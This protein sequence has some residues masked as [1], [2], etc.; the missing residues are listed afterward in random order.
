MK[1]PE[2][3]IIDRIPNTNKNADSK[4]FLVVQLDWT[5][6]DN[7]K[8]DSRKNWYKKYGVP[9]ATKEQEVALK[10]LLKEVDW[11]GNYLYPSKYQFIFDKYSK[12]NITQHYYDECLHLRKMAIDEWN[13]Q[14]PFDTNVR[15]NLLNASMSFVDSSVL[16]NAYLTRPLDFFWAF[17]MV[18]GVFVSVITLASVGLPKFMTWSVLSIFSDGTANAPSG[19][20]IAAPFKSGSVLIIGGF[21]FLLSLALPYLAKGEEETFRSMVFGT[22]NRIIT[23]IKF[24]LVH[25]I[26]GVPLFVALILAVCGYIFSIFYVNAFS[27]AA[28]V[29]VDTADKVA[30]GVS[31]SLHAKYNFLIVTFGALLSILVLLFSK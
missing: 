13:R 18:I 14:R 11:K 2:L 21:W 30:I 16:R 6:I 27:K 1:F 25:M 8:I 20:I 7:H 24:G 12:F 19:N 29:N 28:K 17:L 10:Q 23:N 31:T 3:K 15:E 9:N 22:K 5:D 26:V 4:E